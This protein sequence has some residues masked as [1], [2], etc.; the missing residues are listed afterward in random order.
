MAD[1]ASVLVEAERRKKEEVRTR[2]RSAGG[3][4]LTFVY[5][6]RKSILLQYKT[7]PQ[8]TVPPSPPSHSASLE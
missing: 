5:A 1:V 7:N 6:M 2:M 8:F 4:A 3:C